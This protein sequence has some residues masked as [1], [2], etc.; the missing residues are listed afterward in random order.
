MHVQFFW[1]QITFQFTYDRTACVFTDRLGP[2]YRHCWFV[3]YGNWALAVN[4]MVVVLVL[5]SVLTTFASTLL[6]PDLWGLFISTGHL[7]AA[8]LSTLLLCVL[9]ASLFWCWNPS[10]R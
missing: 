6:L 9:G 8:I 1:P 4:R 3:R 5:G 2:Y 10:M 7:P